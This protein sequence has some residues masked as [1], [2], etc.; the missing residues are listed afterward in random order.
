MAEGDGLPLV[1]SPAFT[2]ISRQ[3]TMQ[4]IKVGLFPEDRRDDLAAANAELL[5]L[6]KD[7][8]S[9][10]NLLDEPFS[11]SKIAWKVATYA[12]AMLYRYC[13]L[14]EGVAISWNADNMLS[15]IL[16]ARAMSETVAMFWEFG[17]RFKKIADEGDFAAADNLVMHYLFGTRD[18]ETLKENPELH[19]RQVL[20]AIDY[21]ENTIPTFRSHYDRLSEFCH[22]NSWGQRG[23]FSDL[24]QKTGTAVFGQRSR[25]RDNFA[26]AI[27]PVL[28][29]SMLFNRAL[30]IVGSRI[31]P[32]AAAHHEA[33]PSPL[34]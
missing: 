25:D 19:A 34:A 11:K 27:I 26:A 24:D 15:A 21:V 10:I 7:R 5:A 20:N 6:S 28:G 14:A 30:T 31:A 1:E 2:D 16:S 4:Q 13:S 29:T 9:R 3:Q 18:K 22:P 33:S 12:N 8:Q 23:M 32:F 17:G